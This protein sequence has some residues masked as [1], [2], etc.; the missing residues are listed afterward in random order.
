MTA[1]IRTTRMVSE[2]KHTG[3]HFT[4]PPLADFLATRLVAA[5]ADLGRQFSVL[6]PAC[7]DGELLRAYIDAVGDDNRHGVK[8]IGVEDN[9]TAI[10]DAE[11]R[12]RPYDVPKLLIEAD[13]LAMENEGRDPHFDFAAPGAGRGPRIEMPDVIIANPPYVRTQVLGAKRA[14]YLASRYGL[15]GRVDLYHAFLVAMTETLA[16]DG[17]LGVITSNRFLTTRS[18]RTVR[19]FLVDHY[20][21][22]E[23]IDLGDTKLFTA[24]VLPAILIARKKRRSFKASA[25]SATFSR[26]YEAPKSEGRHVGAAP[27]AGVL[28]ALALR[29]D[30]DYKVD[31]RVYSVTSGSLTVGSDH[32]E[33]WRLATRADTAWTTRIEEAASTRV[34]DIAK[35]RVGIKTTADKIFIRNDWS[36]LDPSLRPEDELLR[37]LFTHFDAGRWSATT[38]TAQLVRIL[39]P[40]EI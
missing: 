22:L 7:G 35:V 32:S 23:V 19:H 11:A 8:V 1:A 29:R 5:G 30:G 3:A 40:H 25:R 20:D 14:Q 39:Y 16:E 37:P 17:L 2:T 34:G 12:L 10:A 27:T 15:K 38:P 24:A 33:P 4:P 36:T 13:F 28:S 21:L 31:D 9:H 6:D 26:V 18:G